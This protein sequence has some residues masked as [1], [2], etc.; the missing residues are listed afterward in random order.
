MYTVTS[1]HCFVAVQMLIEG[2][3]G[4]NPHYFAPCACVNEQAYL[5]TRY[6]CYKLARAR[7]ASRSEVRHQGSPCTLHWFVLGSWRNRGDK[8]VP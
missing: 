1:W 5:A 7:E 8:A 2:A 3:T 4:L 6:I